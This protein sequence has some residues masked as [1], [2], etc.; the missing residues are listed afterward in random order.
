LQNVPMA[1]G[2]YLFIY[3]FHMPVFIVL[4]GYMSRNWTFSGGKARRL[5]T[6]V[7]VPYV[8]FEIAYSLYDWAGTGRGRLEISLLEPYSLTWF[9]LALFIW[10][11]STPVCQQVVCRGALSLVIAL[12]S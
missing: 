1:K 3:M 11:L 2:L 10:R 12:L 8:V 4:T 9:P 6:A 7:G 5:I